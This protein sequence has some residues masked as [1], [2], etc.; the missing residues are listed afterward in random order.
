MMPAF[1]TPTQLPA[2]MVNLAKRQGV[3]DADN[4]GLVSTAEISTLQ[5]EFR[6]LSYLL[7]DDTYW[8]AVEK[9]RDPAPH[10]PSRKDSQNG[11]H[12]L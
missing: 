12:M 11:I 2:S 6:Y 7:E 9:V 5:L 4:K 8:D 10:A 3:R 1:D